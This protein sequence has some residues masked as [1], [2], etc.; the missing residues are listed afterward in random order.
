MYEALYLKRER[1]GCV[2]GTFETVENE[3]R[4]ITEDMSDIEDFNE[5]PET[6][7]TDQVFGFV[8][9]FSLLLLFS[10]K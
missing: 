10:M 8:Q 7:N 6:Q 9:T 4:S 3:Q 2:N 5:S 1:K